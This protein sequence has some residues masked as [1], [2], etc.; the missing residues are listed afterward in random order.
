MTHRLTTPLS[1]L[2]LA[3]T[4]AA[5]LTA[6][7]AQ[8]S[9]TIAEAFGQQV[10]VTTSEGRLLVTLPEGFETP[11]AGAQVD[12]TGTRNGETFAA[13]TMDITAMRAQGAATLPEALRG[14]GLSDIR[15]RSDKDG[16]T[17]IYARMSGD[18][19]L[20]AEARGNQIEEVQS[21]SAGLPDAL[22]ATLL[23]DTIRNEPRVA[24]LMRITE[25]DIDDDGEISIEGTASD[26]MRVEM[27]FGPMGEMRDYERERDDRT[28]LSET[29]ARERLT[30]LGYTEIGFIERGG[31]KVEA[32]AMNPYGDWVEVRL[33][34]EGRLD[35]ERLWD[36]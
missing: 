12:L 14:L 11:A 3:A 6:Q 13:S 9:G 26:G 25:I 1:A 32:Q 21:E 5:P 29:A 18:G 16:D 28:S 22:V 10:I 17:Y 15:S 33:D 8:L 2:I 24:K 4:L 35:R 31:R 7:E 34:D 30:A 19:W 27:E 23:P 36:R 20:R